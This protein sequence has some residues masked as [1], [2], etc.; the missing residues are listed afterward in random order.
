MSQQ[1]KGT[2]DNVQVFVRIRPFLPRELQLSADGN[3]QP[4]VSVTDD[5]TVT[6]VESAMDTEQRQNYGENQTITGFRFDKAFW[7]GPHSQ[8]DVYNAS[9]KKM[10]DTVLGGMNACVFA[11]GQ[12]GSGKTYT[13]LGT[14]AEPGITP[15]L[16][17]ELFQRIEQ[18]KSLEP[19]TKITVDCSFFE[20]YNETVRDLMRIKEVKV[21]RT[22][23]DYIAPR[24]RQHPRRGVYVDGV[25]H[26]TVTSARETEA[27]MKTAM[28]ERAT[29]ST[30][31]NDTSSRSHAVT[32][33]QI[34][35]NVA[36]RG[37]QR[38][39]T[40]SLVDLAGSEKIKMSHATG[41]TLN[42]T[43]KINLSL[44]TLRRVMDVLIYNSTAAG[45]ARPKPVPVRES[46]LT[47]L[48]SNSLGGNSKTMMIGTISPHISN[49][50]DT[51]GTL[52]YSVRAKDIINT[53]S[54]NEQTTAETL[55]AMYAE[56]AALRLRIQ[57]GEGISLTSVGSA[58]TG[59][60]PSKIVIPKEIQEELDIRE[61]EIVHI[62][63]VQM[64]M[65]QVM[66][67]AVKTEQVMSRQVIDKKEEKQLID[68]KFEMRNAQQFAQVF[69]SALLIARRQKKIAQAE[70]HHQKV[71]K[72]HTELKQLVQQIQDKQDASDAERVFL[73]SEIL[74]LQQK[75]KA[76][77]LAEREERES[78][79]RRLEELKLLSENLEQELR[80]ERQKALEQQ[81]AAMEQQNARRQLHATQSE[82]QELRREKERLSKEYSEQIL[83]QMHD[84]TKEIEKPQ[85]NLL[86]LATKQQIEAEK[87]RAQYKYVRFCQP[88][89]VRDRILAKERVI[90]QHNATIQGLQQ[91]LRDAQAKSEK[92]QEGQLKRRQM[93]MKLMAAEKKSVASFEE[94]C[95]LH[96]EV[97]ASH[98]KK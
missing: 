13:M 4:C 70:E 48:L 1:K 90:E 91:R 88:G 11:Y 52:R 10:L 66:A 64:E 82:I 72:R 56:L 57:N 12:T 74:S 7:S 61:R 14:E 83:L 35:Q 34:T 43:K 50:N 5:S 69:H 23:N 85:N 3:P 37:V 94:F 77:S 96:R 44:T 67:E 9:A 38:V 49:L 76:K 18:L 59:F 19:T 62:K 15:R 16:T 65:Q 60:S 20:I 71:L 92:E 46:L 51:I 22:Q 31:M 79:D 80:Q 21:N 39:S 98:C 55:E 32:Q 6:V 95:M 89:R 2:E 68:V 93:Q 75:L 53:V 33:L 58:E 54:I 87:C 86:L 78:L 25:Q 29:A 97:R 40:L 47:Y 36:L 27:L 63:N 73:E 30:S 26:R 28:L 17:E 84:K 24:V 45:R 81:A 41:S 8:K 42:E